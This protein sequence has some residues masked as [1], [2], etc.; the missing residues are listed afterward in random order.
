MALIAHLRGELG[1]TVGHLDEDF[2][3]LEGADEGL[4]A[5]HVLAVLHGSHADEEVRM[6]R[7]ADGDSVEL[8]AVLVKE[9]AEIGETLCI[10]VHLQHLLALLALQVDV[11]KRYDIHHV[12]LGELINV[13]L[14]AIADTDV[15]NPHFVA[16]R[17]CRL[18]SLLG[19]QHLAR[20][21]GKAGS[22]QTHTLQEI[23]SC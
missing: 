13:L 8:V 22:S 14:T 17:C 21:Q 1:M 20:S 16:L 11:A 23:S 6:V 5:I 10:G 2:A 3:L 9:L 7:H 18:R 4:L 19:S 15:G 12:R